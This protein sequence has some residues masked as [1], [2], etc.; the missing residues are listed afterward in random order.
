MYPPN[1]NV[2]EYLQP[3]EN[4]RHFSIPILFPTLL[5]PPDRKLPTKIVYLSDTFSASA[6][7]SIRY[8]DEYSPN[9]Y[10][11][12]AFHSMGSIERELEENG[13]L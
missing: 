13:P 12:T 9:K 6:L 1:V 7:I 11:D 5:R 3:N 10:H 8:P 4:I 2:P